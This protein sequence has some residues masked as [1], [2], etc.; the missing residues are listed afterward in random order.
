MFNTL[1]LGEFVKLVL[2]AFGVFLAVLVLIQA[3]K[4]SL[5]TQ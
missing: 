4:A 1:P 3:C 2:D 5:S